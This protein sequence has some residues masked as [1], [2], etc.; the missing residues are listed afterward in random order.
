M[1]K[2]PD[3]TGGKKSHFVPPREVIIEVIQSIERIDKKLE[4]FYEIH[5]TE[6]Q[7]PS[8]NQPNVRRLK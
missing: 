6:L 8:N 7:V 3:K 2:D 5:G 4:K 1:D